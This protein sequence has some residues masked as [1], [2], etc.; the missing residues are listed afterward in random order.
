MKKVRIY[1]N[2]RPIERHDTAAW[3]NIKK[4]KEISKVSIPNE[5]EVENAKDWVD[6]NQK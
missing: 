4:L 6:S 3:A 2:Y 1:R 5:F